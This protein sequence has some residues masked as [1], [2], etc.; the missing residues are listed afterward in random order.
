MLGDEK[1]SVS[2]PNIT[3][4]IT[5]ETYGVKLAIELFHERRSQTQ[6]LLICLDS[7]GTIQRITNFTQQEE[8]TRRVQNSIHGELASGKELV[9]MWVPSHVG[10]I[11]NEEADKTAKEASLRP[12]EN[13]LTPYKDFYPYIASKM[14]EIWGEQWTEENRDLKCLKPLPKKWESSKLHRREEIVLNRVRLGHTRATHGYLFETEVL[15]SIMPL[16]VYCEQELLSIRHVFLECLPL[17][18][19]RNE[20]IVAALGG[21]PLTLEN[22]LGETGAVKAALRFLREIGLFDRI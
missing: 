4:I 9:L 18:T 12:R 16:C 13:L 3:S 21:R 5:A 14:L 7:L 17:Q 1:R 6:K 19:K 20:I 15:N 11:G 8:L 2:M 10:I 22:V